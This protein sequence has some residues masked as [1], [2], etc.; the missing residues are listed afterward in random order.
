MRKR[1][2]GFAAA[3]IAVFAVA[4][5]IGVAAQTPEGNDP[6]SSPM[7]S[8]ISTLAVNLGIGEDQLKS[9]IKITANQ[10]IDAAVQDGRATQDQADK[11]KERIANEEVGGLRSILRQALARHHRASTDPRWPSRAMVLTS[12]ADLLNVNPRE[13]IAEL[14]TGK[15]IAQLASD[16]NIG[17]DQL[18]Q[19][20]LDKA[21][22]LLQQAVTNGRITTDQKGAKLAQL[23]SRLDEVIRASWPDKASTAPTASP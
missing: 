20:I 12:V 7:S 1:N 15:S 11:L 17:E 16:P 6:A 23:V 9:A 14:R 21:E 5:I 10:E 18:K 13:L 19:A 2:I 8:F 4:G 3:I 22:V